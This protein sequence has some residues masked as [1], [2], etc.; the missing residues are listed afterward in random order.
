[1]TGIQQWNIRGIKVSSNSF[2]KVKKCISILENVQKTN[3]LS[4]QE[5]HLTSN[6]EIPKRLLN[7]NHL[8]HILPSHA[9]V[10]DKG[11]GI[12]LF[13]NKTEE[14]I[15]SAELVPGRLVYAKIQNKITSEIRNIF[16]FYAKSLITKSEI[17]QILTV[18][19]EKLKETNLCGIIICGDFNF[20]TYLLDRNSDYFTSVDSNYRHEWG[21]LQLD[22]GLV[23]SFRVTNPKRRFYTYTHTN[24]TSRAR[25]DRIYLSK[26]LI[27]KILSS[28][29]EYASESDHKIVNLSLAKNVDIGP[30][31]WIF[32]NTLLSEENFVLEIKATIQSFSEN[33]DDFQS[34]MTLWEFLKQNIASVAKDFSIRKS[35]K[36]RKTIEEVR[37][38][39]EVLETISE[40]DMTPSIYHSIET[41][42]Q[43]ENNYSSKKIRGSLLRSKLPG[44]EEGDLNIAYY[45][46][47]EKMRAEQNTVFSLMNKNGQL[48]EGTDQVSEV[49]YNFYNHLYTKEVECEKTQEDLL[50]GIT[51]TLS[52][53]ERNK[54]DEEFTAEELGLSMKDLKKNKSPGS[55]GLTKEFYDFFWDMLCPFYM[56][57]IKEIDEKLELTDSQ[58]KGLIRISYKKMGGFT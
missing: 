19:D 25:L 22:F 54:L 52:E 26:D 46:K 37:H 40:D 56:D 35:R 3:I 17:K 6:D 42:K 47:L 5:T 20:V 11:A 16:S 23:D 9:P 18:F 14:L 24:G 36:E 53:E 41:L 13:I 32:N 57:C 4:I 44:V 28:N 29:F 55:D 43:I 45:T 10:N 30:G 8:Y 21:K 38:K 50:K 58:K 12:I 51:I 7:F 15:E 49:I 2:H 33:K 31:Q 48:V 27:G 34:N 39:I 1:M